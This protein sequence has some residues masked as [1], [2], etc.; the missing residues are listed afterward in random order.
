MACVGEADSGS[1]DMV[2]GGTAGSSGDIM[3]LTS[4]V[5]RPTEVFWHIKISSL[6]LNGSLV[7]M[8]QVFKIVSL[9]PFLLQEMSPPGVAGIH[10]KTWRR[11]CLPG[12]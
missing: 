5:F 2:I 1:G 6:F 3:G 11:R 4:D 12:S 9:P 10:Q 8:A 7:R